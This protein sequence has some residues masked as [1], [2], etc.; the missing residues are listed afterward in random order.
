MKISVTRSQKQIEKNSGT[1]VIKDLTA[2][3]MLSIFNA[4]H[5]HA[6]TSPVACDV[7]EFL[8]PELKANW[9]TDEF[10]DLWS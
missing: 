7:L 5:K 8:Y 4:I 10:G 3:E 1:L 6:E 9:N 2:G